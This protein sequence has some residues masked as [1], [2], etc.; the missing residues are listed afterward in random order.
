[1]RETSPHVPTRTSEKKGTGWSKK[2]VPLFGL[3]FLNGFAAVVQEPRIGGTRGFCPADGEF[4]AQPQQIRS[5]ASPKLEVVASR[6]AQDEAPILSTVFY[7]VDWLPPDFGAVGQYAAMFSLEMAKS[8]RNVCLIGL[9]SAAPHRSIER[10]DGGGSLE[11]SKIKARTYN[12]AGLINRALWSLLTN[13]RLIWHVMR[14]PRAPG[15]EV[16]FTGSPPFMLFI[17]IFAKWLRGARLTYRITDFYPEVLVAALGRRPWPLAILERVTWSLRRQIDAFQALGEDQRRLLIGGGIDPARVVVKRDPSPIAITGTERPRER[18]AELSNRR[19]LLYS[20]NLGIAHDVD[21]VVRGMIQH[22]WAGKG[23][24]GLWL[25]ASGSGVAAMIAQLRAAGV[26]V[27]QTSP[28]PL[29]ELPGLLMAA[30]VHLITL[31][32]AFAGIVL[33]SK[34]YGCLQSR[35]PILFVGPETSDVHALSSRGNPGGYHHVA[36]GDVAAF[37]SALDRLAS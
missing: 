30:D 1:L 23:A 18:P 22:H 14:D 6:P 15:S 5:G 2:L 7:I 28:V 27:A 19:V 3:K 17:A 32:S 29:N 36:P 9:T 16:V 34:V 10:F 13:I 31:R 37:A 24:F 4:M 8:G 35:R 26:P 33:P 20:G 21:T 12:K 11:I 25:N